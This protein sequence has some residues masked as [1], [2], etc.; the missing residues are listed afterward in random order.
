[1]ETLFGDEKRIRAS[2]RGHLESQFQFYN[3]SAWDGVSY[4]RNVLNYWYCEFPKDLN[5]YNKFISPDDGKNVGALFELFVFTIF[6]KLKYS[7]NYEN[8]LENGRNT[9]FIIENEIH[10]IYIDCKAGIE[11]NFDGTPAEKS[12]INLVDSLSSKNYW[13]N[14]TIKTRNSINPRISIIRKNLELNLDREDNEDNEFEYKYRELGWEVKFKFIKKYLKNIN[15]NRALGSSTIDS[16][17]GLFEFTSMNRLLKQLGK[18]KGSRYNVGNKYMIAFSSSDLHLHDYLIYGS[19][20]GESL[21]KESNNIFL[22][23][24]YF[25]QNGNFINTS[26]SA[27][28]IVRNFYLPNL[29]RAS[30]SIWHNPWAKYPISP[31]EL[32][33]DSFK[34]ILKGKSIIDLEKIDGISISEIINIKKDYFSDSINGILSKR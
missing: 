16:S 31:N 6:K 22:K 7:L 4:I 9:D 21:N 14:V 19:L 2:H 17:G 25:N 28:L 11:L 15:S 5:F 8:P 30:I 20:Y 26:V 33:F 34:P 12:I 1:M 23:N 3:T 18:K 10:K 24:S 13:I 27:V 32:P 29:N